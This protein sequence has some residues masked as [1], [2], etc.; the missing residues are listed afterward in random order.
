VP[1]ELNV[2]KMQWLIKLCVIRCYVEAWCAPICLVT[3]PSAYQKKYIACVLCQL[4]AA[5]E[6]PA[7]IIYNNLL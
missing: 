2:N 4:S 6:K 1:A 5:E 7:D 3:L